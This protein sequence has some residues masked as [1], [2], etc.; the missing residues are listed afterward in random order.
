MIF[1]SRKLE[2]GDFHTSPQKGSIQDD[3]EGTI[4]KFEQTRRLVG[5]YHCQE[6]CRCNNGD[7]LIRIHT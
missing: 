7:R 5:L 2:L 1:H 6:L 3:A 4:A